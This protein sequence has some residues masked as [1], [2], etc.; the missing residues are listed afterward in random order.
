MMQL[1]KQRKQHSMLGM[2]AKE[3]KISNSTVLISRM[4]NW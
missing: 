3:P 1:M 4:E 2:K